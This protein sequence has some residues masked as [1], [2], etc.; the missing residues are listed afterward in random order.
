[1]TNN[2]LEQI[3]ISGDSVYGSKYKNIQV[4]SIN[5]EKNLMKLELKE[6]SS[7]YKYSITCIYENDKLQIQDVWYKD[8]KGCVSY[9]KENQQAKLEEYLNK[10][11]ILFK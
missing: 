1:M 2:E 3:I 4:T 10:L 9:L 11:I 8:E 6:K 5:K 7:G